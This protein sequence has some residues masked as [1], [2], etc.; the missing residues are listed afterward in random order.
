[1]FEAILYE[2]LRCIFTDGHQHTPYSLNLSRVA[3]ACLAVAPFL[4]AGIKHFSLHL[5]VFGGTVARTVLQGQ[6]DVAKRSA[7]PQCLLLPLS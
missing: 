7:A 3:R 6:S 1:M 5:Q 4:R 2:R